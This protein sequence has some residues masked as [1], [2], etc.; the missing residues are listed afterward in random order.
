MRAPAIV[1]IL[2]VSGVLLL[3]HSWFGTGLTSASVSYAQPAS[4]FVQPTQLPPVVLRD[5]PSL[6][7]GPGRAA[8]VASSSSA[9]ARIGTNASR[10]AKR[11]EAVP[12]S[13]AHGKLS[14][15]CKAPEAA[16][17][18]VAKKRALLH[19]VE[20][21]RAGGRPGCLQDT[22]ICIAV[23]AALASVRR[24][25]ETDAFRRHQLVVTAAVGGQGAML[26]AFTEGAAAL[27]VPVLVL[28][29][30]ADAYAIASTTTAASVLIH[31]DSAGVVPPPLHRKWAALGAILEAGVEVLWADVDAVLATSPFQLLHADTDVAA[32][33]EGW[34]EI[35]MRGH[36]MGADDPSMGWSRYCES[37]RAALLAPGLVHL[38]P[39]RPA[40]AL[41][42][43]MAARA[44]AEAWRSAD[45]GAGGQRG[46][47]SAAWAAD[48]REAE[49][50]STELLMPAHD[51]TYRVGAK[52]RVLDAECWLHER[53]A[54]T[55]MRAPAAYARPAVLMPGRGVYGSGGLTGA[56]LGSVGGGSGDDGGALCRQRSA[57]AHYHRGERLESCWALD[58][59]VKLNPVWTLERTRIDPLMGHALTIDQ[60]KR[61]VIGS[62]CKRLPPASS[63]GNGGSGSIGDGG[64]GGGGD[65][66]AL[67]LLVDPQAAEWPV[68]CGKQAA[69]CE[70]VRKVAKDRAVMAA[71]S[72]RNILGMLGQ[73]VDTVQRAAVTNFLVV[74]LDQQTADF[75]QRRQ[76]PHYL[77]PLRTRTGS[78]DNHATSGL[79]FRILAEL[80]SVGVSVLLTDVDVVLTRDPFPALYR[81][82]DV[83]G[84]TDGWDDESAYGHIHEL[85]LARGAGTPW[86]A[87]G[88]G[89]WTAG[90]APAAGGALVGPAPGNAN[91][92]L[93]SLRM[94]ARNSGLF[95]LSATHEALRLMEILAARMAEEDVWDQSA[96]N[97]EIFRPAYAEHDAAGVSVRSMNYL[98]FCNTKLLFKVMRHDTQL[99]DTSLHVPVTVHINYHP[100]K[101]ARMDSVSRYY[102]RH[103]RTALDKWNG[104]EGMRS[105]S[106]RGKVGVHQNEMPRLQPGELQT[107]TLVKSIV[108]AD[109]A[110]MWGGE[111]PFRFSRSG[112]LEAPWG[113][114]ASWGTVP[115]PWRK[116][117]LH[118]KRPGNGTYLLMFLSEKWAFVALR[119]EDEQVS[120]GALQRSDV[121]NARLVF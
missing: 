61:R 67:N 52:L 25:G 90:G 49:A 70:A 58:S 68:N 50:L 110:W 106:C 88:G 71:V 114:G 62:K 65:T 92:P 30:D 35:F 91:A 2:S 81:D 6:V 27:R 115:S 51:E 104:G 77:R 84:M 26:T 7:D 23:R 85:P 111:G 66:R 56:I 79:K 10:P 95:Y 3:V 32:L 38:L 5:A 119:C 33:S 98:C 20:A 82:S 14:R 22:P 46:F 55:R 120:Y 76:A 57:L 45:G 72:N 96:Y 13:V 116:D 86:F 107:H 73:F 1:W 8:E 41:A 21:A 36:V 113:D 60:N 53:V 101:E 97:M 121:P 24:S 15:M 108:Q 18:S 29:M 63:S 19:F 11:I 40:L 117:S 109:E 74:A 9:P 102:H 37:M 80:L 103:D 31:T 89:H 4:S 54:T 17:P 42:R 87:G 83:E 93:R 64:S 105:G 94:V 44:L 78:T 69:L 59:S 48:A 16:A 112:K 43:R 39:T 12:A 75:L 47:M 99:I 100:E 34:E 28:A 118:V